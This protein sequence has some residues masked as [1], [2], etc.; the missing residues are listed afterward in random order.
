MRSRARI[1]VHDVHDYNLEIRSS[2]SIRHVKL[3]AQ[4]WRCYIVCPVS[5]IVPPAYGCIQSVYQTQHSWLMEWR[6]Q[7]SHGIYSHDLEM[8]SVKKQRCRCYWWPKYAMGACFTITCPRPGN[9][10]LKEEHSSCRLLEMSSHHL[11]SAAEVSFRRLEKAVGDRS[12]EKGVSE[13]V[14]DIFCLFR[15]TCHNE[16]SLARSLDIMLVCCLYLFICCRLHI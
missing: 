16:I 1:I 6:F 14:S 9:D 2:L 15:L 5:R 4:Q 7:L 11:I 13:A 8:Q 10:I 3:V 12:I